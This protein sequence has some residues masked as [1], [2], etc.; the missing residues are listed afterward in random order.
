MAGGIGS[1]SE[2]QAVRPQ[3]NSADKYLGRM[4]F[5][6]SDWVR[7]PRTSETRVPSESACRFFSA[8]RRVQGARVG[9]A[10]LA[11][12]FETARDGDSQRWGCVRAQGSHIRG[13]AVV[14]RKDQAQRSACSERRHT[15]EA[16]EQH[17]T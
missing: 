1:A 9:E 17:H 13:S 5:L 15:G 7:I 2:A 6:L 14:D 3:M 16:L 4:T 12:L 11:V 8:Q 10:L